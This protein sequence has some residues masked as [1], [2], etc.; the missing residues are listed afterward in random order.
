LVS[1]AI[2]NGDV[3]A[4]NYFTVQR[5]VEALRQFATSPNQKVM[6]LPMESAGIIGDIAEIA[7]QA[8]AKDG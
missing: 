3:Q 4:I 6:F 8:F 5:Y 2:A 1:E 7:K